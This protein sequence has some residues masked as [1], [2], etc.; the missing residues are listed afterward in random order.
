[1]MLMLM[2]KERTDCIEVKSTTWLS[3]IPISWG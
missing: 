2:F 3:R 1:L